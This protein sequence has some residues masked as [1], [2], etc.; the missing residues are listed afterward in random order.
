[1][2]RLPAHATGPWRW[3]SERPDGARPKHYDLDRLEAADGS[4]VLT[5]YSDGRVTP[6]QRLLAAAPSLLKAWGMVPEDLRERILSTID[7]RDAEAIDAIAKAEG[8][9]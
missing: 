9:R 3:W 7:S 6:N 8:A 4:V 1:M 2:S 5:I